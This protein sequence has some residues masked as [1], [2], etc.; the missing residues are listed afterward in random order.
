MSEQTVSVALADEVLDFLFASRTS[1]PD[2]YLDYGVEIGMQ[3]N[4]ALVLLVVLSCSDLVQ[5][6]FDEV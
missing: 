2:Q 4:L 1:M 5:A 3:L 6:I